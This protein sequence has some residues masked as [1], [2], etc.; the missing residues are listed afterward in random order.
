MVG[1]CAVIYKPWESGKDTAL[2]SWHCCTWMYFLGKS[3]TMCL[4]TTTHDFCVLKV[5]I[6]REIRNVINILI[7]V[8]MEYLFVCLGF[9]LTL[10]D[11]RSRKPLCTLVWIDIMNHICDIFRG[12][13]GGEEGV[14][15]LF[16]YLLQDGC[17]Y[18]ILSNVCILSAIAY[19]VPYQLRC[20]NNRIFLGVMMKTVTFI[21]S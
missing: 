6:I 19:S 8:S 17:L 18:N 10:P 12:G 2:C 5:T 9:F 14:Y 15:L 4:K 20:S 16:I 7:Q 11:P 1:C 21:S 3:F 13:G